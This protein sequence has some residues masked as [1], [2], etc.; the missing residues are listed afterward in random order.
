MTNTWMASRSVSSFAFLRACRFLES[1]DRWRLPS[2]TT[3]SS[4]GGI[5]IRRLV[6]PNQC[7]LLLLAPHQ[8]RFGQIRQPKWTQAT[9]GQAL[10]Q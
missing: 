3:A 4:M 10:D 2:V 9:G 7:L 6:K 8:R 1:R 5:L